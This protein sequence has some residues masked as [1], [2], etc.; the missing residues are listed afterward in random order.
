MIVFIVA[1]VGL[2]LGSFLSVLIGRWPELNGVVGGRSR[3]PHCMM[4]LQ[5][6]DLIPLISWMTLGG[7]CR[8]CRAPISWWYPLYEISMAGILVAYTLLFGVLGSWSV[9]EL[10]LL[11]MFVALFFFDLRHQVLPDMITIP[12]VILAVGRLVLW[13]QDL[14]ING[15]ATG[16]LLAAAF[17]LLYAASRGRVLGFGDVK[18]ALAIGVVFGFPGA[19]GVTLLAIW[20][21]ALTGLMLMATRRA[22][23]QT[24]LPFGS[25]WTAVAI[26]A[27]LWPSP[28]YFLSGLVVPVFQ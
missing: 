12:M 7:K 3:C 20:A 16:V 10:V 5:W 27:M 6:Y 22:T 23:M 19:V 4:E 14:L 2:M 8:A 1:I 24:A 26:I 18:L 17:G 13:R 28:I 21:G 9:V 25:F 11:A 15:V